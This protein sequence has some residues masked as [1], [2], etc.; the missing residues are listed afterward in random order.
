MNRK[1]F[2]LFSLIL[3]TSVGCARKKTYYD[4]RINRNSTI[5]SKNKPGC[6]TNPGYV[7]VHPQTNTDSITTLSLGLQ[8]NMAVHIVDFRIAPQ[9]FL[10]TDLGS[11]PALTEKKES[12]SFNLALKNKNGS[13]TFIVE[14]DEGSQAQCAFQQARGI[15]ED[16]DFNG[17]SLTDT[18]RL[19]VDDQ[20]QWSSTLFLRTQEGSITELSLDPQLPLHDPVDHFIVADLNGDNFK[21]AL[22]VTKTPEPFVL[23]FR[24]LVSQ[25]DSS[26]SE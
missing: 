14:N 21:D 13:L 3:I 2:L 7:L 9:D 25:S 23:E 10:T 17:D 24:A 5:V 26:G 18:L 15:E 6:M 4:S 16:G 11:L 8:N 1:A 12:F 20:G 22:I 19:L